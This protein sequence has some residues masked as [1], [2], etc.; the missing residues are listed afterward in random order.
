LV[1]TGQEYDGAE[2]DCR[3]DAQHEQATEPGQPTA[4]S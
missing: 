2:A 3:D 1:S 4:A